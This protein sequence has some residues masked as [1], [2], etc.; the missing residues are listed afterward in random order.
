MGSA[1]LGWAGKT[2]LL[3][4]VAAGDS[5][6]VAAPYDVRYQYLAGALP[7]AGG[8]ALCGS[9]AGCDASWW[10]CWQE[11]GVAPGRFVGRFIAAAKTNGQIPMF[12]WYIVL[13]ASGLRE[14]TAEV[15]AVDDGSF[16]AR[17]LSD[18]RLLLQLVG[19]EKAILHVE[20]DFW[21]YG[22]H[23]AADPR[24]VPARVRQAAPQECGA[25]P[26]TLAGLGA[27]MVA[28]VRIHAPNARVG[29]HASGWGSGFDCMTNTTTSL[30]CAAEGAKVGGWLK[31]AGADLGD[32]VVADMSDRDAGY[33]ASIGRSTWWNADAT[34]PSFRQAFG[35]GRAVAEAVGRPLLW[36][37]VPV[38]NSLQNDSPDH[39]RDNRVEYLLGHMP[40]VAAGH[41]I[42][43]AFGAGAT[44]Q[45]TP[46]T[47]GGLLAARTQGYVASGGAPLCP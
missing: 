35:W 25:L 47:D 26:D 44:G 14:G 29:L 13:P 9:G 33:Y 36:W 27:C 32:L 7:P 1:M 39:W 6:A 2:R 43:V 40:E 21:G 20:P 8:C 22:Q 17:Y 28:M 41:A 37:Q 18:W 15:A 19:S 42:G 11:N 16:L 24:V 38:G 4:G 45:T 46:E 31:L 12:T 3:V 10:G 23:L 34:L 5:A 30:D